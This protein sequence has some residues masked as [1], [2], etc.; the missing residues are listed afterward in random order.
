MTERES[1]DPNTA[2]APR[3]SAGP[4]AARAAPACS[5]L[6]RSISLSPAVD[7]LAISP[8]MALWDPRSS[9]Q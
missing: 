4:A 2:C 6:R 7:W 9:V 8:S 1:L 5:R 3:S